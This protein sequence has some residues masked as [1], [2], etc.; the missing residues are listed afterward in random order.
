[1]KELWKTA[2]KNYTGGISQDGGTALSRLQSIYCRR[3]FEDVTA[4]T[5]TP[6]GFLTTGG[7]SLSSSGRW[8]TRL[9]IDAD[10]YARMQGCKD[11]RQGKARK[12]L[13]WPSLK[14][15]SNPRHIPTFLGMEWNGTAPLRV[16]RETNLDLGKPIV[17]HIK[18]CIFV[19]L[20]LVLVLVVPVVASFSHVR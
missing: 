5:S 4:S 14:R 15:F 20:V 2:P 19:L 16:N 17:C 10:P 1:M 11:A 12:G 6:S 8:Q 18:S 9:K 7:T 3:I 13:A